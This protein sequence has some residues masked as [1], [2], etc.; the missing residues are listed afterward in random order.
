MKLTINNLTKKYNKT[1]ILDNVNYTFESNKIY[2]ILGNNGIG[3]TT[4][5]NCIANKT[6]YKGNILLDNEKIEMSNLGYVLSESNLPPFL[7]GRELVDFYLD[8]NYEQME[9]DRDTDDFLDEYL[10]EEES[11]DKLLKEYSQGMKNKMSM[12]LN[13]IA[14]PKI[15]LLDEPLIS[16]DLH[17]S[18]HMK[19]ILKKNKKN[20]V[21]ILST[22]ILEI[23]LELSDEIIVLSNKKLNKIETKNK[24]KKQLEEAVLE[25]LSGDKNVR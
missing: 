8:I 15:T 3:K 13:L 9:D 23:A 16:L 4:L 5:F 2:T 25:I 14:S 17:A 1:L 22:H 7:T 20:S 6:S 19:D 10:I 12:L 18:K 21:T 11:R 24:T